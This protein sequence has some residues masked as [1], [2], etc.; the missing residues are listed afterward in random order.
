MGSSSNFTFVPLVGELPAR[1][2]I[3]R[4]LYDLSIFADGTLIVSR[5]MSAFTS[6]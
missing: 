2:S 4:A 3:K 6:I 1:G 5:F